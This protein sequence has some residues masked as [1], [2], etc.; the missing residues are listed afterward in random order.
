MTIV[1]QRFQTLVSFSRTLTSFSVLLR[2]LPVFGSGGLSLLALDH[3]IESD[4]DTQ[5]RVFSEKTRVKE[6][7][8]IECLTGLKRLHETGVCTA[9]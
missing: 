6:R 8:E 1:E 4:I 7:I 3:R 2:F 5:T 9:V